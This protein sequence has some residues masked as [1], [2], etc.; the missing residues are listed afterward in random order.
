MAGVRR[1]K[2]VEI[3]EAMALVVIA[4]GTLQAFFFM[5]IFTVLSRRAA[6]ADVR[7]IWTRY[8]RWLVT[9]LTFQ[10]AADIIRTTLTP[11]WQDIGQVAAIAVIRTFLDYCLMHDLAEMRERRRSRVQGGD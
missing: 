11:S 2:A 1:K 8:A 7:Q 4:M 3:I 10:L 9:G 5:G 6:D